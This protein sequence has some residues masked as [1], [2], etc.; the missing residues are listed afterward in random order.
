[1]GKKQAQFGSKDY[2]QPTEPVERIVLPQPLEPT[3]PVAGWYPEAWNTPGYQVAVRPYSQ[4]PAY[5]V[6]PQ[7]PF[8]RYHGQPPGGAAPAYDYGRAHRRHHT[9]LAG[10]VK[11]CFVL[12][13]LTLLA[14]VV[15]MVLGVTVTSLWLSLL[16]FASDLFI[17]PMR[18]L[19]ASVNIGPLAGTSLLIYL[20]FLLA[21]IAYGIASRLLVGLLK[22][23]FSG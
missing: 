9:P 20:E 16:F 13:Q 5:P 1:M 11:F 21:I 7:A 8:R 14:R 10:L 22:F 23:L 15:C 12:V 19:A 2:N 4:A 3:T 17:L 18:W 6:L